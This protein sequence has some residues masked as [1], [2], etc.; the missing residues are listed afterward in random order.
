M[1]ELD[2]KYLDTL[3]SIIDEI[4]S[5]EILA[6]YLE[7]EDDDLYIQLKDAYEPKIEELHGEVALNDPLQLVSFEQELLDAGLEGLFLPRIL[8]YSVLRG[9][10]NE[11]YKYVRPQEHFKDI[12]L[13][14][15]NSSNFDLISQRIGQTVEVGF[16]LSSDI[17][18]TNLIAEIV[19]K[20]VSQ[21]LQTH[22]LIK[23]RDIRSR[24]TA[25]LKYKRQ[26]A[27]YN[28]L[29][30][31]VPETSA[32][33]KIESQSILNFLNYRASLSADSKDSVYAFIAGILADKNLGNSIEHLEILLV[34][35]SYFNL[36]KK[37]AALFVERVGNYLGA[38]GESVFFE[39][40]RKLQLSDLSLGETEYQRLLSLLAGSEL[41]GVIQF[42]EL[43][44]QVHEVGYINVEAIELVRNFYN[45]NKGL[46]IEN[47]C[48]RNVIFRKFEEFMNSLDT[49]DF[50]DYFELNKTFI[51]YMNIF[52]NE[53]FN[54]GVKG[55]SMKYVRRLLKT[56]TVKRSKD[57]QDI[58][59]FV[60]STFSDLGFLNAKE[61]KELFKTK[62][63]K[64]TATT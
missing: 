12:L 25:Y 30:A 54:Q 20:R 24:H 18:I 31:S 15:A 50:L 9:A 8:G 6:N 55:I 60:T 3:K 10:I 64:A 41:K 45:S 11:H 33:I 57:Y 38:D 32:D 58:K 39:L 52:S 17:W 23:F 13:T 61:I 19:N 22:K 49:A 51:V 34:I 59:K 35:G 46:S 2:K 4:Q 21:F 43:V 62:R 40:I 37:E 16:A 26:F 36:K 56:Y 14:I 47:E 7:E 53:K 42:M 1:I 29:T 28:F 27:N 63:K 48:M 44:S 5:S